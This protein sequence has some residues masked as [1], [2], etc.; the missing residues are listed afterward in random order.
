MSKPCR[1]RSVAPSYTV[2]GAGRVSIALTTP[3]DVQLVAQ[4]RAADAIAAVWPTDRTLPAPGRRLVD[5]LRRLHAGTAEPD[6]REV[7]GMTFELGVLEPRA[8]L[9]KIGRYVMTGSHRFAILPDLAILVV[10]IVPDLAWAATLEMP[11]KLTD[12]ADIEVVR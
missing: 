7:H 10:A 12:V 5:H 9:Q 1:G 2:P 8:R 11:L 3:D 6:F 4:V